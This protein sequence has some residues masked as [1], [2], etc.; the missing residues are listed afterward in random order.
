MNP[1]CFE[2]AHQAKIIDEK[3]PPIVQAPFCSMWFIGLEFE[4]TENL[5]VDLT[6]SIQSFTNSVHKHAVSCTKCLVFAFVLEKKKLF[7]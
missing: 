7:M 2:K 4:K 1:K 6:E 3:T 5:N